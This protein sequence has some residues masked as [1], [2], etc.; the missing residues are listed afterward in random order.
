MKLKNLLVILFSLLTVPTLAAA[1]EANENTKALQGLLPAGAQ[2][3]Q[4]TVYDVRGAGQKD[5]LVYYQVAASGSTPSS[6][7][8]ALVSKDLKSLWSFK[9]NGADHVWVPKSEHP[10]VAFLDAAHPAVPYVVFNPYMDAVKSQF[11]VFRWAGKDFVEIQHGDL[12]NNPEVA[13][14]NDKVPAV[15]A[16]NFGYPT[17]H[18]FV[19]QNDRLVPADYQYPHYFDKT[20]QEAQKSL[21][22]IQMIPHPDYLEVESQYLG[23]FA[24]AHQCEEGLQFADKLLTLQP[25]GLGK[26]LSSKSAVEIHHQKGCFYMEMGREAEAMAE[27]KTASLLDERPEYQGRAGIFAQLGD[28]YTGKN[29]G[30]RAVAAYEMAKNLVPQGDAQTARVLE[31]RIDQTAEATGLNQASLEVSPEG[32][33]DLRAQAPKTPGAIVVSSLIQ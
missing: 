16:D 17:P 7:G 9:E 32:T 1:G 10:G 4:V 33:V 27:F 18:L 2:I 31:A 23:A 29:D 3:T 8:V 6:C 19:L 22:D 13:V 11:H 20:V 12:G 21:H 26:D 25:T 5:A 14:M 24:Y 28:Y 30:N 15:V